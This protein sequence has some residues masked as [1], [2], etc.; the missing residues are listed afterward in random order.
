[1]ERLY[2]IKEYIAKLGSIIETSELEDREI[3]I[4]KKKLEELEKTIYSA[5]KH[6]TII[7]D[8]LLILDSFSFLGY[9]NK[10]N[11]PVYRHIGINYDTDVKNIYCKY[12]LVT[13][14]NKDLSK[15]SPSN[16]F[17]I[18]TKNT[19][20]SSIMNKFGNEETKNKK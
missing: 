12:E 4:F 3:F 15:K 14:K 1:M 2:E 6:K 10:S 7:T 9:H 8:K 16:I 18:D 11:K 5:T 13:I 17:D 20:Y 19:V